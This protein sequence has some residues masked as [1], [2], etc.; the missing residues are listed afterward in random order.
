MVEGNCG[1][2][3]VH[4]FFQPDR[5]GTVQA[6]PIKIVILRNA[7]PLQDFPQGI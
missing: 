3:T 6:V 1:K 4:S 7:D 5:R 2:A